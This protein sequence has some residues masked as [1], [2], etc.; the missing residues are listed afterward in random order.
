MGAA[1]RLR[2]FLYYIPKFLFL[3]LNLHDISKMIIS[4]RHIIM[5]ERLIAVPLAMALLACII[6]GCSSSPKSGGEQIL[7]DTELA[8]EEA[9]EVAEA[10]ETPKLHFASPEDAMLYMDE[11]ADHQAYADGILYAMAQDSLEYCER[12]LNNQF[13]HFIIVDKGKMRVE[14]Y[15]KYGRL[16]RS[17]RCACG[18]GFG[19]KRSKGDC[20]T[21]E[22]FFR[23]AS[24][25]NSSDWHYTDENGKRSEKPGQ[26]GPRFV[27]IITPGYSSIGI[28]GTD[29]PWSIGG[30]RS[31][32]CVRI[33]NENILELAKFVEKGMPIIV[34]PGPKDEE[35]NWREE[36]PGEPLPG[37]VDTVAVRHSEES[38]EI[39][40]HS[41]HAEHSAGDSISHY[42]I[43]ETL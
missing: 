40:G 21:P 13:K 8:E 3:L 35:V 19:N 23:A 36:H 20:R 15:D 9:E 27:R 30:R 22:G 25:R 2:F 26:Y 34:K 18:R 42:D 11:S 28:H 14:L 6:Y 5:F 7:N 37:D 38:E 29:A 32:G 39:R 41:K 4:Y 31:H 16:K 24:P 33:K 17:Y 1:K 12:L 43:D 10:V